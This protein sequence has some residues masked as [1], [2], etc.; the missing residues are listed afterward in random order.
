MSIICT[1]DLAKI[2]VLVF[3]IAA[4]A[5]TVAI[6]LMITTVFFANR[7]TTNQ[8]AFQAARIALLTWE[9]AS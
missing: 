2:P 6:A 7:V 3:Q 1:Q 9:L 5:T 4:S 8:N